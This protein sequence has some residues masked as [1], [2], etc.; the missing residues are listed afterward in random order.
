[1]SLSR[2]SLSVLL[3]SVLICCLQPAQAQ[4]ANDIVGEWLTKKKDGKIEI[5]KKGGKY[6][7]RVSW[8][9]VTIDPETGKEKRDKHNP[10]PAKRDR[11]LQGMDILLGCK[12]DPDDKRWDDCTVYNPEDGN[13]YNSFVELVNP[14]KL[15][16]RGYVG[17][18]LLG[19]ST[20]WR[21][22]KQ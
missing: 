19:K 16:L 3:F 22:I 15:K 4:S 9:R 7:G 18:S 8:Q 20:Y 1:M 13:S 17:F 21:R 14:N 12:W 5:Y 6:Y 2:F 10:D 11:L